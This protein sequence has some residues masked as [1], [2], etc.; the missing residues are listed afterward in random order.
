MWCD[1]RPVNI[2]AALCIVSVLAMRFGYDSRLPAQSKEQ[3]L[4]NFGRIQRGLRVPD[5]GGLRWNRR[6]EMGVRRFHE[7]LDRYLFGA[8][9]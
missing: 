5:G 4:A 6:Q 9:T 8:P 1:D 3:D 2:V 7:V